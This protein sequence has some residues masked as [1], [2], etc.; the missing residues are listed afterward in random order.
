LGK[1]SHW[2]LDDGRAGGRQANECRLEGVGGRPAGQKILRK[3]WIRTPR[4]IPKM[5]PT[6]M[7]EMTLPQSCLGYITAN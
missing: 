2:K 5:L 4:S 3:P 1:F 7:Q 6:M